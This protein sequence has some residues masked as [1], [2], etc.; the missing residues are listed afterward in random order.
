M[1][2]EGHIGVGFLIYSPIAFILVDFGLSEAFALGM[3]GM[4][5]W[6]IAPDIDISL[7]IPHRGPTHTFMAAGIAGLLSAII[8]VYLAST[9]SGGGGE[10]VIKS[11]I[12]A[13]LAAALFGFFIGFLG[14]ISHLVGDVLT[15]AGIR[16]WRPFS[17]R[18]HGLQLVLARDKRA[19]QGL[20]T[21]GGIAMAVALVMSELI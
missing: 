8:A 9:G 11:P 4:G 20:M 5:F 15:M 2:R 3:V 16:P 19:N 7:P 12:L 1:H 18:K 13:S 14:V 6:S 17:E 21:V 10:I